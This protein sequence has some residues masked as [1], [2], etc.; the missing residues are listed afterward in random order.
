MPLPLPSRPLSLDV[1]K[2][3]RPRPPVPLV[4]QNSRLGVHSGGI[5]GRQTRRLGTVDAVFRRRRRRRRLLGKGDRAS[6]GKE[7]KHDGDG[8]QLR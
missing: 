6:H 1:H 3:V 4:L 5:Q 2:N 8:E 7:S